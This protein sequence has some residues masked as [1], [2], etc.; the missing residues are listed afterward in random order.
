MVYILLFSNRTH[1]RKWLALELICENAMAP[2][3]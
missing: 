1:A 2:F 3:G